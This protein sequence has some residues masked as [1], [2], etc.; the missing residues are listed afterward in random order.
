MVKMTVTVTGGVGMVFISTQLN[1]NLCTL[2]LKPLS[3]IG[4]W[5]TLVQLIST[6][7]TLRL[8]FIS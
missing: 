5:G 7:C 3:G 2:R 6:Q 1:Q 8:K 4:V